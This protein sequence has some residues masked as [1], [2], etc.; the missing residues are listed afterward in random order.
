MGKVR[1]GDA[2]ASVFPYQEPNYRIELSRMG[3]GL[4]K[5]IRQALKRPRTNT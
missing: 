4:F 1:V 5:N 3:F 2:T